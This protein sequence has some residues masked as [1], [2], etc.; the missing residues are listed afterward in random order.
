MEQVNIKSSGG[1]I[2]TN[3]GMV[4]VHNHTIV[5]LNNDLLKIISEQHKVINQLIN[6]LEHN[7]YKDKESNV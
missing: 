7:I 3:T 1:C 2:S 6:L 5:N 4:V